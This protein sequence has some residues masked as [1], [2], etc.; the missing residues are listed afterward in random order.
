M[1]LQKSSDKPQ[2]LSKY[3]KKAEFACPCGTCKDFEI[4][5]E[6]LEKLDKMRELHGGPLKVTSGFRCSTYQQ[7]L[8]IRGY[9]TSV[10]VSTHQMGQAADVTDGVT[11]GYELADQAEKA[12]FLAIGIGP[13]WV[14]VDLRGSD[15]GKRRR[16]AYR[17]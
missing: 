1:S 13:N 2:W 15:D 17:A 7:E 3:F 4:D 10:G 12:G 14:H 5:L 8:R 6:L 9:E 11:P 16:W